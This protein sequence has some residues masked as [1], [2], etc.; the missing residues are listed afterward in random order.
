MEWIK[1]IREAFTTDRV[2]YTSHA[3]F[4]MENEEFSR[5]LDREVYEIIRTGEVIEEYL[6]D[7]PYPSL[8]IFG[9]T[10]IGRP[11]HTVCSYNENEEVAIVITVYQPNPD[12]W[13][14]Y[15]RRRS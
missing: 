13:I 11:L 15:K 4:E 1:K 8:L 9:K 6:T 10:N 12:L 14:D 5:I 2:Y 3:K 7:K